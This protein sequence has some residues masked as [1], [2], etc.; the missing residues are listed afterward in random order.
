M[1][2]TIAERMVEKAA[3]E[4]TRQATQATMREALETVLTER[5]GDLSSSV[6]RQLEEADADQMKAW[7]RAALR[8]TTL[9]DVGILPGERPPG[10]V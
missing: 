6:R 7:H 8:A 4:A 5:F 3:D 1:G 2:Q 10:T 9:E